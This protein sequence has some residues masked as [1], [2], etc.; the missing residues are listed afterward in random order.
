MGP[1]VGTNPDWCAVPRLGTRSVRHP[2]DLSISRLLANGLRALLLRAPRDDGYQGDR[3]V[4]A[5]LPGLGRPVDP[6]GLRTFGDAIVDERGFPLRALW[7][8]RPCAP[9]RSRD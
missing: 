9:G 1:P 3:V 5:R 8:P 2:R 6:R 4:G 7:G